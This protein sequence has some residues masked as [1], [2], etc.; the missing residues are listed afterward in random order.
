MEQDGNRQ[1]KDPY[2]AAVRI[3]AGRDHSS[4]ELRNKLLAREFNEEQA[5]DAIGRLTSDGY[6]DDAKFA[7]SV[8]RTHAHLGRRGLASQMRKKGLPAEHWTHL[9]EKITDEEEFERALA[10]GRKNVRASDL[11]SKDPSAWKRRLA[12]YLQRRGFSFGTVHQVFDVFDE[13]RSELLE[14]LGEEELW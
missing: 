13:E 10:A 12:G 8:A 4:F 11:K 7:G 2:T 3:L 5:D 9:V 1:R 6:V 14:D